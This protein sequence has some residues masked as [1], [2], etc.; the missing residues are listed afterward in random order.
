M[1]IMINGEAKDVQSQTVL[2]LLQELGLN[3]AITVVEKNL[4]ILERE[5]YSRES[6]VEGDALELIRFMGG[7]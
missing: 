1:K 2:T 6:L 4:M 5:A 3:P 7:G